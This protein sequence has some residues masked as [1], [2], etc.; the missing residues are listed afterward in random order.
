MQL[1][2]NIG[3]YELL[4]FLGGG[5]SHVYRARDTVIDRAVV[6]KILTDQACSDT[7]AKAR[8]LQEARLAGNIQH[9]NIVSVFDYGEHDGRPF[10]VMEYLKGEDLREAIRG[11]RLGS[12]NERLKIALDIAGALDY[13]HGRAIVHRDI[14]PENIHIDP[15]GRVKL[16]DFG[17][18]KTADLALTKTGMAMGTPYY[19]S[20]EQIAGRATSGLV[21]IYAYGQVL[22]E[23]LTGVR[24]VVGET[25]EAV[26]YQILNQPVDAAAM[27]QAGAP[28]AVR[29]LVMRCT[30]KKVEDRPQTFKAIMEELRAIMA[31]DSASRTQ[32][33][34]QVQSPASIPLTEERT[35]RSI[36]MWIVAFAL[37]IAAAV[38]VWMMQRPEPPKP[39]VQIPGMVYIPAGTFLAGEKKTPTPTHA[40]YIDETEVSNAEFCKVTGCTVMPGTEE[41][42]VVNIK[43]SDARAYA[44]QVGKRLPFA[45]EWERA[46]RGD[47]GALF[48]WGNQPDPSKANVADNPAASHQ[49]MSVRSFSGPPYNMIGNVWE[50]IDEP[51]KPSPKALE[52]F[53]AAANERWITSRGG[54]FREILNGAFSWDAASAPESHSAS[55]LGFRCVKDP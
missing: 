19:M 15:N 37:A 10:I 16:M 45:L 5:M 44:K 9:E 49:V 14:K 47:Q 46:V 34:P 7:E 22:F 38:A 43:V 6:V 48:P 24:G 17:I 11:A 35:S 55:D 53:P 30:A 25:M 18:A 29:D 42:P 1:P 41:L 13:V 39:V 50:M 21:D 23:I 52:A 31:G 27:E 12:I 33:L 28:P 36:G 26:F 20:P 40:F 4:E 32:A 2:A 51:I 8:F 3:K 54:S